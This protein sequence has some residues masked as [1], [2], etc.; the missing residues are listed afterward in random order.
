[1][2][3]R[4]HLV[5]VERLGQIII[6]AE[7][8]PLHLVLDASEAGEDEDRRLHLGD[9]QGAQHLVA[10]HVG[11]VQVEQ[12][13]VVVVELT[14]IDALLAEIRR[15]DVEILGLEHQLDALRRRAVILDQ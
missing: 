13:N 12:D 7:A 5:L 4:H 11:K 3:T 10:G 14:E 6:G 9:T 1:M 15:I 2:D 8:E